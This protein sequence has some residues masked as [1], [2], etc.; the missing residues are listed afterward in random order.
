MV[1]GKASV[2]SSHN[3][4]MLLTPSVGFFCTRIKGSFS[5]LPAGLPPRKVS[6]PLSI[7]AKQV[8][9]FL[10]LGSS[11][12]IT[13]SINTYRSTNKR[14]LVRCFMVTQ[15]RTTN[16]TSAHSTGE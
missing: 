7:A 4:G 9:Q 15:L 10:P 16:K 13:T 3:T 6:V 8:P 12:A 2:L 1:V 14:L 11:S 5:E